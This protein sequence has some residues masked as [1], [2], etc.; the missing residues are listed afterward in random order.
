MATIPYVFPIGG[1][2]FAF[3]VREQPGYIS[4]DEGVVASGSGILKGGT[5][6][7]IITAS[8]KWGPF[9]VAN[10]P[11]GT[12]TAAGILMEDVDATSADVKRTILTRLAEVQRAELF[13]T[14]TPTSPQKDA[15]YVSLAAK[16]IIMR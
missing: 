13:F 2:N 1:T 3:L 6:M 7:G 10:T 15:A 14:G 11:A 16:N 4:R 8:G 5:V 9:N 12:G